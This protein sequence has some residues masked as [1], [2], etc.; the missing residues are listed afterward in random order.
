MQNPFVTTYSKIPDNSYIP[1]EQTIEIV[2]NFGYERPTESV[3]KITGVRG[4]GKTVLLAK[5]E[6]EITLLNKDEWYVYR[7][8]P[9]RDMLQQLLARLVEDFSGI[10]GS[11]RKEK[12]VNISAKLLG[13][14]GEVGIKSSKDDNYF[15]QGLEIE[16]LLKKVEASHKKILIGVDEISKKSEVIEFVS[17]FGTWLR[18]GYPI[19]LVCTG[20][21]ENIEQLYN[22]PNL[23]F[24]RRATTVMTTSLN[25]IKMIDIYRRYLGIETSEARKLADMTG[26]YA[27]AFQELGV[28][29]FKNKNIKIEE[30]KEKLKTELFAYSYEKIWEEMSDGDRKLACILID[31][32]E[33]KKEEVVSRMDKPNNY[34][35]Y[36]DRLIRKGILKNKQ[37]YIGF[38]LPY[39]GDY[40]K[41]Y[42][43]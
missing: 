17:E 29:S 24:F 41:E 27:Y 39:F 16:K 32:A 33:Y 26:G 25:Y 5:V 14:G 2:E 31:K 28:I 15:D 34:P 20:L 22:V 1:T 9:A 42:K 30:L 35:V 23:T 4:S 12:S 13:L 19:F 6:E 3:Y 7:I 40:I 38:A 37:G 36:R 11:E 43:M 18:A 21:Y 8:S 10:K